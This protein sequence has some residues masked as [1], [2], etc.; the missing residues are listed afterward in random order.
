MDSYCFVFEQ[1]LTLSHSVHDHS[2]LQLLELLFN[3][4]NFT[5]G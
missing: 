3:G 2:S 1:G 4:K 5:L